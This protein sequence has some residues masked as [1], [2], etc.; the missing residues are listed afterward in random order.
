MTGVSCSIFF[1]SCFTP[2]LP[3][4][5]PGPDVIYLFVQDLQDIDDV[6]EIPWFWSKDPN[7]L[8][9][10]SQADML[11]LGL[12]ELRQPKICLDTWDGDVWEEMRVFHEIFGFA[13]DSP[14]IPH[15]LNLPI[16]SVEWDGAPPF[17]L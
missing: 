12:S 14:D 2:S 9:R 1:Q 5:T 6:F 4:Q 15:F 8:E 16:A 7:G 13:A 3:S 10:L 17:S 11:V